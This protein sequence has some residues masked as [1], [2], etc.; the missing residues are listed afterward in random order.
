MKFAHFVLITFAQYCILV[1]LTLKT[2][3]QWS[4]LD[5]VEKQLNEKE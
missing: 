4:M 1:D 3:K 2:Q 5:F